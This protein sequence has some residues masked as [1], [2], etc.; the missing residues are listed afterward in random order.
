[1]G[2]FNEIDLSYKILKETSV[3]T[4]LLGLL[5]PRI[6]RGPIEG[7]VCVVQ[8]SRSSMYVVALVCCLCPFDVSKSSQ[9]V[10]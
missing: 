4:H 6:K 2:G 3:T 5:S 9:F 1:M 7:F 8:S 10:S